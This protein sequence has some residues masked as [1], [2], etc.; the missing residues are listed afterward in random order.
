MA[1]EKYYF[2]GRYDVVHNNILNI[3][4]TYKKVVYCSIILSKSKL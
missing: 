4:I 2:V 1:Y 3:K